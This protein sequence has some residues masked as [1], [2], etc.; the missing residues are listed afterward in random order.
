ML[1]VGKRLVNFVASIPSQVA[2]FAAEGS[3]LL[4]LT[5][6]EQAGSASSNRRYVFTALRARPVR[7]EISRMDISS[8]NAQRLMTFNVATS[9]TPKSP[10]YFKN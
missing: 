7:L 3:S 10:P 1:S 6:F 2:S 9:I 4:E 8:R 5:R